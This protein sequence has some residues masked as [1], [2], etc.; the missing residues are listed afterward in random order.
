MGKRALLF[1]LVLTF[2]TVVAVTGCM[3]EKR[4]NTS[5]DNVKADIIDDLQLQYGKKFKIIETKEGGVTIGG[6]IVPE[7]NLIECLDDGTKFKYVLHDDGEVDNYFVNMKLGND[8]YNDFLKKQLDEVYGAENYV[9]QVM[10]FPEREPYSGEELDKYQYTRDSNKQIVMYLGVI[11]IDFDLEVEST[12]VAEIY[13]SIEKV[14]SKRLQVGFL[15]NKPNDINYF[16]SY[17]IV[18]VHNSF[19]SFYR[20]SLNALTILSSRKD[21]MILKANDIQRL[22]NMNLKDD[23]NG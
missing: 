1:L 4:K 21:G 12:K 16:L 18:G 6:K 17:E 13:N 8:Y 7:G 11:G 22:T 19:T 2:I 15:P 3:D 14:E 10:L 20:D 9:C 5:E 23:Q